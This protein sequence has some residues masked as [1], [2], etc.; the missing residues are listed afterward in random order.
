MDRGG[1]GSLSVVAT[2]AGASQAGKAVSERYGGLEVQAQ[3][4][5]GWNERGGKDRR[6]RREEVGLVISFSGHKSVEGSRTW[7]SRE[8]ARTVERAMEGLGRSRERAC[9]LGERADVG[10]WQGGVV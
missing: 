9:V 5:V 7:C 1:P 8:D 4:G 3:E 2:E 10:G 6:L